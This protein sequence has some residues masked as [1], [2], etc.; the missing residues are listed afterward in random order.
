M[1]GEVGKGHR[2][3]QP[4]ALYGDIGEV[5]ILFTSVG[6]V[7]AEGPLAGGE[8]FTPSLVRAPSPSAL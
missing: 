8:T 7:I 5:G 4:R 6:V 2:A 1:P 3:S